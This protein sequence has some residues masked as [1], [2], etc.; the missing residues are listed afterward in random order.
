VEL[1]YLG[2]NCVRVS[3]KQLSLLFD[4]SE[5]KT[6]ADVVLYSSPPKQPRQSGFMID[7]PGEY[8][9]KGAY[10]KGIEATA[11]IDPAQ[12]S[13]IYAVQLGGL[14]LAYL[15]NIAPKLSNE[16]VEELDQVDVL[17]VPVG[18]HGLTLDATGAVQIIS[19]LEPKLVVPTH[20]DDGTKYEM[21]QD[22]LEVFL[23]EIGSKPEPAA[24]LKVSSADLPLE[25]TVVVLTKA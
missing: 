8:E 22:K 9:I 2:G 5:A 18:G 11:H 14:R 25:T 3:A 17:V 10:I 20:Y 4:P 12:R 19:Q 23:N 16:Q 13:T 21:P 7:G 1:T 15:G 6:A 24:K